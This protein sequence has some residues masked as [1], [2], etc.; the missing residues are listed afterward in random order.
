MTD[1]IK[2]G[3][4]SRDF[5]AAEVVLHKREDGGP[6]RLS[7][8]ASSETPVDRWFGTEVLQ[9]DAKS[10]RMDRLNGGAAPLLFNHNWDD[11]VGMVDGARIKDSRLWVDAHFFDTE[12]AKEVASMVEGG[13]RNV[14]IG[15]Q[16]YEVT[17]DTKKQTYTATDWGV[18]EVSFATVPADPSVG[19]G[20]SEDKEAKPVRLVREVSQPAAPAAAP[21]EIAT[22][23]ETQAAAGVAEEVAARA[24]ADALSKLD[25]LEVE[26]IRR[27]A[28]GELCKANRIDSRIETKWV[29]E[30]TRLEDIASKILA[31]IE[32]RGK[33]SPQSA[34]DIGLSDGERQ[35][36]SL[37]RAMRLLAGGN[38]HDS[39]R[40]R[41]EAAFELQCSDQVAKQ[42]GR[43]PDGIFV[44]AE[45]LRRPVDPST[46]QRAMTAQPGSNGGYLVG[47]ENMGFVEILRNRSV[48]SRMGAR[49][50]SGLVGNVTIPRQTGAGTLVWQ[51]GETTT[52]TAADQTL[53]QLSM[54]PKTAIAVTDVGRTLM[55]QS[56][57]DAESMIM[58]DLAKVV[59][60]GVDLAGIS[61]TGGAQ[62]IG[63]INTTG[64][65]TGQDAS[66][67]TYA[68]M[69]GFQ[70]AAAA[71]NAIL[72]NPGYVTTPTVAAALMS[73]SRFA[74]TDTP[75]WDGNILDG[76]MAGFA[77]MSSVQIP[78]SNVI[79][80][81]WEQVVIG[82]W[83]VL[84]LTVN[85][86]QS[87]NAGVVGIRAIYTVD[88]LV[89]YPQAF[90]LSTNAS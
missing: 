64:I 22:M 82:E 27:R 56:S 42:L 66:T 47:T 39:V 45:V 60:L 13:M 57:P 37:F 84:E 67:A 21:K 43:S 20:R 25:P 55:M 11:P 89:R 41:Q 38:S 28:I 51:A 80:G 34:A 59:A 14:S 65:T 3:R 72:G 16:L 71:V 87:F 77:A 26:K 49:N 17:E 2:V 58:G 46:M 9:H 76:K 36:Y 5:G 40:L 4:L 88:V 48:L 90:V 54:T 74:N 85:P 15:Y 33:A 52:A 61:G 50:L 86:Y 32:E 79:F 75:L 19:V 69:L 63:I 1:E 73:R 62:P 83:G 81:S 23:A 18:L 12:R 7:F 31:T 29:Q 8:P 6:Q 68:K 24:A 78:T 70:S 10:V 53:G 44:P 30:G 35:R